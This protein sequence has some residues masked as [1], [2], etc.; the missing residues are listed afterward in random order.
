MSWTN[1]PVKTSILF[2]IIQYVAAVQSLSCLWLFSD[3]MDCSRA[4]LLC[5][6]DFPGKNTRVSCHFL[7]QRNLCDP[8]TEPT[9]PTLAGGFL[10]TEPPGKH[11]WNIP[12]YLLYTYTIFYL[13]RPSLIQILVITS[14]L[15]VIHDRWQMSISMNTCFHI[16]MMFLRV[17]YTEFL[18]MWCLSK[19]KTC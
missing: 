18:K 17:N 16:H 19:Y 2:I 13:S 5:P 6:W 14:H 1:L 9:I 11:Y 12:S 8:G 3:P 4:K 15:S 10:T 7:L